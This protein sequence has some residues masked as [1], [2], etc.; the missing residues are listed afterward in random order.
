MLRLPP[1]PTRT[2]TRLPYTP[3]CRSHHSAAELE[4]RGR[5]GQLPLGRTGLQHDAEGEGCPEQRQ[6]GRDR[7]VRG[8][9]GHCVSGEAVDGGQQRS[10]EHTSE[11]QSLMRSS[12]AVFFLK[13]KKTHNQHKYIGQ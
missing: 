7:H 12:Y 10:E 11:L 2:D 5:E 3:L 1:R 4:A 6:L 13:K 9:D 8:G